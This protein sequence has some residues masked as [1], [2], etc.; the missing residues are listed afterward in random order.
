ML[1]CA[2]AIL[3]WACYEYFIHSVQLWL[4]HL[5]LWVATGSQISSSY[6]MWIGHKAWLSWTILT[7]NKYHRA[8]KVECEAEMNII[9]FC[10]TSGHMMMK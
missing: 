2:L 4:V 3:M 6:L 5:H 9:S 10:L 8:A 7:D 1:F